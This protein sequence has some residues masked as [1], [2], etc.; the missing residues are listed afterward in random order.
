[1]VGSLLH[2]RTLCHILVF[3]DGDCILFSLSCNI[4]SFLCF[5]YRG[6]LNLDLE[7]YLSYREYALEH[8]VLSCALGCVHMWD[9]QK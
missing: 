3:W 7:S 4:G 6:S 2:F 1:M 8:L 9:D 5:I